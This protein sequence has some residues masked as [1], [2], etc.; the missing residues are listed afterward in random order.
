MTKK[1]KDKIK[2]QT[3][4]TEKTKHKQAKQI[5]FLPLPHS[6][7]KIQADFL[8]K[9][10]HFSRLPPLFLS[11]PPTP[12]KIPFTTTRRTR[13]YAYIHARALS[14]FPIFA[15]TL[16]LTAQQTVD[17]SVEC[18]GKPCLH[19]H[20]HRNNLIYNTLH[21]IRCKKTGEG[22]RVKPSPATH[23][24]STLYTQKVKRWRQKYE[25]TGRARVREE[26]AYARKIRTK[27]SP[28]ERN[29]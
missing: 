24:C 15:F 22:K 14:E 3:Y 25:I 11:K 12:H 6:T 2:K 5:V 28:F 27:A 19:L 10:L 20:L 23:T 13:A 26:N 29:K 21:D 1:P 17:Q 16:H 7:Q 9:L 4:Y 18:E 8:S